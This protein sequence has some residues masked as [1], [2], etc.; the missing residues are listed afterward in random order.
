[1]INTQRRTRM[2]WLTCAL[3]PKAPGGSSLIPMDAGNAQLSKHTAPAAAHRNLRL[4]WHHYHG[5]ALHS[6]YFKL[7][8]NGGK[9]R[10]WTYHQ[11][12]KPLPDRWLPT[13]LQETSNLTLKSC[14][15]NFEISRWILGS[16]RSSP[17]TRLCSFF[18]FFGGGSFEW[19]HSI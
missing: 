4:A 1:M 18:F 7:E 5:D 15:V 9:G 3:R 10:P 14:H 12:P 2:T 6:L 8:F 16:E 19:K 13:G 17:R 11:S